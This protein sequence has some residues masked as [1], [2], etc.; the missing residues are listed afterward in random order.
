MNKSLTFWAVILALI[1]F[2]TSNVLAQPQTLWKRTFG[3]I[4]LDR[5]KSVVQTLDGGFI[6]TGLTFSSSAG[7]NDLYLI[8]TDAFGYTEWEKKFGGD[9]WEWGT[10]VHQMSGGG[11]VVFGTT[12]SFGAGNGDAWLIKTDSLGNLIWDKTFGGTLNDK[13]RDGIITSDGGYIITGQAEAGPCGHGPLMIAKFDSNGIDKWNKTYQRGYYNE[14]YSIKQTSDGGYIIL[15]GS[16][17]ISL[18]FW[19]LKT[20]SFGDTLWTRK[21]GGDFWDSG[22]SIQLT[23]DGGYILA[24]STSNSDYIWNIRLIKTDNSGDLLWKK[25]YGSFYYECYGQSV[26]QTIDGGYIVAGYTES[27][28]AGGMD[29]WLIKTDSTGRVEWSETYG[30]SGDDFADVIQQTAD[31]GYI[32]VGTTYSFGRGGGDVWLLRL[33]PDID[34]ETNNLPTKFALNQNYPNPFNPSTTIEFALPKPEYVELNVFNILGKEVAIIVSKSLNQGN[35]TYQFDGKNLASGVYYYQ[36][37][38]GD[39]REVKKM[40]LLR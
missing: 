18:D 9:K 3:G 32:V 20:D 40:I 5:G 4:D 30:G 1:A 37:M 26:Q 19:L 8:K 16:A 29:F 28:G 12:G 25:T 22:F 35:H 14:G 34:E 13:C 27:Y 39:Y 15:G 38:A 7:R 24:G 36:L 21:Y 11:Y 10:S 17:D 6:I 2:L 23:S 31:G 33:A